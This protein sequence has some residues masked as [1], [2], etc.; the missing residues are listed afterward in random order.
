MTRIDPTQR[1]ALYLFAALL[2]ILAVLSVVLFSAPRAA[3]DYL[4]PEVS[5]SQ[6][7]PGVSTSSPPPV[8]TPTTLAGGIGT[9]LEVVRG[10]LPDTSTAIIGSATW[11][12]DPPRSPCTRGYPPAAYVAAR[13]SEI[14][15]AW[16]GKVVRVHWR[17]RHVDVRL[18]DTCLCKGVRVIDL[19]RAPFNDLAG[20]PKSDPGVLRGVRV[21][22]LGRTGTIALPP[23]STTP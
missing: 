4:P 18:V 15:R 2:V 10:P 19:Y 17:G 8:G 20:Y 13:G 21:E 1:A 14:P 16:Q 22:L 6:A 5:P 9:P 3:P 23:T 12:C 7:Q 11:L